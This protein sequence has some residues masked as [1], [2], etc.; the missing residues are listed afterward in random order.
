MT[1]FNVAGLLREPPGAVREPHL[2]DHYVNLG[3]DIELAGPM[4]IDVRLQRTNRG[5][6][7]RGTARA[8]L[9]RICARCLE[10]YVDEVAVPID[11]EFLPSVDPESGAPL[12]DPSTDEQVRAIDPHHE[13]V[14]DQVLREELLLTEPM[15]P[16]C[17]PDCRGLC[18]ECGQSLASGPH[19]HGPAEIDPRLAGLA[20]LLDEA[21]ER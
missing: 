7:V 3:P 13:I 12:L 6:L 18:A 21:P 19:D 8:A 4:D 20:R 14:L 11:E 15:H 1:A 2:R 10:P 5:V 17:R 9:R 16:L